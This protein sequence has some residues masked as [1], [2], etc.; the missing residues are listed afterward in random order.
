[1]GFWDHFIQANH[2]DLNNLRAELHSI[3][4]TSGSDR[5][6][7]SAE[8]R[9]DRLE[10]AIDG[11]VELLKAK[12]LLT[13][14][15]LALAIQRVDLADGV[16]D[17]R[18]GPDEAAEA[19]ACPSCSRPLNPARK[20]CV[21]CDAEIP[22]A[23]PRPQPAPRLTACDRCAGEVPERSTYITANGVVCEPCYYGAAPTGGLSLTDG[24]GG[25]L[26]IAGDGGGLSLDD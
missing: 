15:E 4:D 25:G 9:L 6:L 22:A 19:R 1:M 17:G 16:E 7:D 24:D 3:G 2:N 8:R 18:I 23:Q 13:D 10:L 20:R 21:Y 26:S 14:D 11:L 5:R 12:S